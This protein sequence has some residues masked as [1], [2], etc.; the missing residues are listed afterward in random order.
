MRLHNWCRK[1][2]AW[3]FGL[4][5]VDEFSFVYLYVGIGVIEVSIATMSK[6]DRSKTNE[7][8]VCGFVPCYQLPNNLIHWIHF[9]ATYRGSRG[10]HQWY[11]N[12]N[13]LHSYE[14]DSTGLYY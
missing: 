4:V 2:K 5:A 1:Q 7:V 9:L 11:N 12:Y 3:G 8:Y 14:L 13:V 6:A 10:V